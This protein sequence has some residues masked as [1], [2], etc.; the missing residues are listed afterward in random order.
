MI[1]FVS[2]VCGSGKSVHAV[3]LS[4]ICENKY[5]S[6]YSN[7]ESM[8]S[9]FSHLA[10]FVNEKNCLFVVDEAQSFDLSSLFN[11]EF[12]ANNDFI[13]ISQHLR[14]MPLLFRSLINEHITISRNSR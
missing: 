12:R 2:G 1:T 6:I 5:S 10:D 9:K 3:G 11:N 13:V 7:V 8:G 4:K 14:L